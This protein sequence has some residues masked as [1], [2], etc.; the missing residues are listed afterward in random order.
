M[1]ASSKPTIAKK[2]IEVAA[3]TAR[4]RPLSFASSKTVIRLRSPSPLAMA[5]K[6]TP[7]TIARAA[8]STK[9]RTT[10]NFTLSPTPRRLMAASKS[11]KPMAIAVM[12]PAPTP[13][14]IQPLTAMPSVRKPAR[15]AE[16]VEAL[17][18]PEHTT[19]NATMKVMKWMP[20]ALCV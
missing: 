14:S 16:A 3:V 13:A 17:V 10:L 18:M 20:N 4:N 8:T 11:M 19:A 2:A 5:K 6:P 9:V 1:T 7:I 15:V 12:V